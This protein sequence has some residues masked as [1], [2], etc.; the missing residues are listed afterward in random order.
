VL[1]RSWPVV[2]ALVLIVL[3]SAAPAATRAGRVAIATSLITLDS[4]GVPAVHPGALIGPEPLVE[5]VFFASA[6]RMVEGLVFRPR[7]GQP[8]GAVILSMGVRAWRL[9]SAEM[10]A[11]GRDFGRAGVVLMALD[12]PELRFDEVRPEQV[13]DLV[14]AFVFLR[15]QPYTDEERVGF[16]GFSVGG[17]LAL[18][19]ATDERIATPGRLRR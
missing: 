14:Q 11:L 6:E 13:E 10:Q 16:L 12:S 18:L 2:V 4:M 1:E 5:S 8:R 15:G 9:E 7:H 3:L 19:A 17:S